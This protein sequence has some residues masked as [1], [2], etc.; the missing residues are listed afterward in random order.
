[1]ATE[2]E[3][4]VFQR[5]MK[6][7]L[8]QKAAEIEVSRHMDLNGFVRSWAMQNWTLCKVTHTTRAI[9]LLLDVVPPLNCIGRPM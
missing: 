6:F 4:R 8:H 2:S 5:G 7:V 9:C 1:M 3:R